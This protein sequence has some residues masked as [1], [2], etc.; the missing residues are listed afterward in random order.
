[1]KEQKTEP[2]SIK[3]IIDE[4]DEIGKKKK[5]KLVKFLIVLF[6]KLFLN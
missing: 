2:F 5:Q 1:M 3:K 6:L 4:D